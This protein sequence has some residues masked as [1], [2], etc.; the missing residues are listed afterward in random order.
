M[1]DDARMFILYGVL[2]GLVVSLLTRGSLGRL[3]ELRLAWAP[4]IVLGMAVQVLLFSTPVGD[5]LGPLA[6]AVY[7]ASDLAVLVAVW[8][9]LAIPGLR[10]VLVGGASNLL[11]ICANGGYMP[12][13]ADALRALGRLPRDGYVNARPLGAGGEPVAFGPLTDIFPMPA[14][15]PLANIFSIG[16]VLIGIGTAIAIVAVTHGRGPLET[17]AASGASG[18]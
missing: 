9:N 17:P 1:R 14:W 3:G 5:A 8:R 11:A 4:L 16:D 7:V 10:V 6:P 15:L 13:S 18:H 12:V 2:V